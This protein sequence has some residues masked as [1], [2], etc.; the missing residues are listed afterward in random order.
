M[1][2]T[3]HVQQASD[4][5]NGPRPRPEK[6]AI[7]GGGVGAITAAYALSEPGWQE[8]W[9]SITVYQQGWRLGGKG[10][11]GRG[12][13]ERIEE[14]GLHVWLGFYEN[15]FRLMRR[16]YQELDRPPTAPLATVDHAFLPAS[17][18]GVMEYH[19]ADWDLWLADFAE[20]DRRP[21]VADAD[22]AELT[23]IE[24][25]RRSLE[26]AKT[27]VRS[28]R[29]PDPT[30]PPVTVTP[31]HP[32]LYGPPIRLRP[33]ITELA[34]PAHFDDVHRAEA[35]ASEI[36]FDLLVS[37]TS[38]VETFEDGIPSDVPGTAPLFAI[39]D[40]VLETLRHRIE[41]L[42]DQD[43]AH[44]RSWF[45]IELALAHVRGIIADGLLVAE[46]GLDAIDDWEY[47]D[48]LLEHGCAWEAAQCSF[49]R[50]LVY[51]LP[52]S[53]EGGQYDRPRAA[54]GT[55]L[56]CVA[57]FFFGYKG[58][59]M[60]KMAAGMG[61]T[62]FAPYYEVLRRRGVRF[63]F[64]QQVRGLEL[65]DAGDQVTRIRIRE[66]AT[67]K[68]EYREHGYQPLVEV[69]GLPCWPAA[70]L[71]HQLEQQVTPDDVEWWYSTDEGVGERVLEHGVDF[72]Q[73]VFG[74]SLG[75]VPNVASEL[76]ERHQ[77]WR[78]MVD[79]IGTCQTQAFQVW[80]R[81]PTPQ[82]G[83]PFG[84]ATVGGYVEP[85]DT[86]ADMSHLIDREQYPDDEVGSIGYFCNVL[87]D[88]SDPD[89]RF[90]P[91]Y[92]EAAREIVKQNAITFLRERSQQIW[93]KAHFSYPSD[94]DWNLLAPKRQLLGWEAGGKHGDP[95]AFDDQ[96][97]RA[98]VDPSE[99]YVQAL[100][101]S[102]RYRILPGDTAIANLV[103]CG[104]WT[105]N[106]LNSGC[107]EAAT[108]SGLLAAHA[109]TGVPRLTDITGYLGV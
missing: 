57:R 8:R 76:V 28:F 26:L 74:I 67:L 99:R 36:A 39:L 90:R 20:D 97:W 89:E 27:A 17:R 106:R 12:V 81:P 19:D 44:R 15:S 108:M 68:P 42:T 4:G 79:H 40:R 103:A 18:V 49:V 63:E 109:L 88:P 69:Q 51:D 29:D 41:R 87:P 23:M 60:W 9:E 85:F 61:D 102:S 48:W 66:Q 56:R 62:V 7:L 82:L 25:V 59:L 24:L 31:L 91:D 3:P 5:P 55:A 6:L 50:T 84:W 71:D 83:W 78:D 70:P 45:V 1:T 10:A 77:R 75:A 21:G 53:Y 38:I 33:L 35:L 11:S 94:F 2:A 13:N 47:V 34:D 92:L 100:P 80:L 93:P 101:G 58:A 72:D 22:D 14:H 104:D 46:E 65:N 95:T 107:V 43:P 86:W 30:D 52:F 54:A 32:T 105:Y 98:N 16:C 73:I 64:F 96:Y 37:A